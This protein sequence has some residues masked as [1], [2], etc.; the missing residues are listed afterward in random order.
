[1]RDFLGFEF[2]IILNLYWILFDGVV[3]FRPEHDILFKADSTYCEKDLII[4][5]QNFKIPVIVQY[6][7]VNAKIVGPTHC[8]AE[9][10]SIYGFAHWPPVSSSSRFFG[11]SIDQVQFFLSHCMQ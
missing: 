4:F 9:M 11:Q 2:R 10:L 7:R 8:N 5:G 6:R 3:V 1:M